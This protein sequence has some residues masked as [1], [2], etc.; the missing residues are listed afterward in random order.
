MNRP[1]IARPSRSLLAGLLV[2]SLVSLAVGW[3]AGTVAAAG[4]T[5]ATPP[6]ELVNKGNSN[7]ADLRASG[8]P[9]ASAGSVPGTTT[10]GSGAASGSTGSSI[11]YPGSPY[12]GSLGAA[13]EGT[14]MAGGTGTADMKT[15]GSDRASALAKATTAAL[16]DARSQAQAV[17]TS[18]G[19]SLKAVY[20][21]TVS[22]EDGYTYPASDCV[23]VPVVTPDGVTGGASSSGT[24]TVT[25]GADASSAPASNVPAPS[26]TS[27]TEGKPST[28]SSAQLVVMVI[29][30][31]TFA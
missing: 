14:I 7:A 22:T 19:V 4:G 10:V 16:A 11:A 18:M 3:T 20:S 30:A 31:Y 21:V 2:A 28:P 6:A 8:N 13:P 23:G 26:S 5:H 12:A 15:D 29:V 17:A 25:N 24:G 27:C 9:E 1:T